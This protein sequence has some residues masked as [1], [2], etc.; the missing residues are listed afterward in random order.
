MSVTLVLFL[1]LLAILIFGFKISGESFTSPVVLFI[2]PFIL[3]TIIAGLYYPWDI[4]LQ[5]AITVSTGAAVFAVVCIITH[6]V[7]SRIKPADEH[8]AI[9]TDSV[10]RPLFTKASLVLCV[11]FLIV[12]VYIIYKAEKAAAASLGIGSGLSDVLGG[13]NQASKAS[14]A[15]GDV[16][17]TG[18]PSLLYNMLTGIAYIFSYILAAEFTF[19]GR[20]FSVSALATF[21]L[22]TLGILVSGSRTAV[23]GPV[24]ALVVSMILLREQTKGKIRIGSIPLKYIL[25]IPA[26]VAL[27]IWLGYAST[28]LI[29]RKIDQTPMDYIAVYLGAPLMNLN[30]AMSN[31]LPPSN[32]FGQFSL[33]YLY[34]SLAQGGILPADASVGAFPYIGYAGYFMGNVYTTYYAFLADFGYGGCL[35]AVVLM[36]VIMQ[37]V[38]ENAVQNGLTKHIPIAAI[39]YLYLGFNLFMSFFSSNFYQ[40]LISTG[41]I[42]S[43]LG[44]ILLIGVERFVSKKRDSGRESTQ[45][46]KESV[47]TKV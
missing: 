23:L 2:A 28:S 5:T 25:G 42:K 46:K 29:G 3:E 45:G 36:A 44:I 27:V 6:V 26:L 41:F 13:F 1:L 8:R 31:G 18:I 20:H 38:F 14:N 15:S 37:L 12:A 22:C 30:Q 21:L 4:E 32:Y 39:A 40:N 17:F 35:I 7:F 33:K 24:I 43:V 16:N 11:I 19:R 9:T 47:L 34:M 10:Y